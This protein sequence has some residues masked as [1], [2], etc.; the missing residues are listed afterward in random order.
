MRK[1]CIACPKGCELHIERRDAG[2][3]VSGNQCDKGREYGEQE[4]IRPMRILTTTVKTTVQ[5]RPRLPVRTSVEVPLSEIPALLKT[6]NAITVRPCV[7]CGAVV[8]HDLSEQGADLI[9]TD[10]LENGESL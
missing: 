10:D 5:N 9:A 7:R 8:M 3:V 1:T 4:A 2:V 6:I